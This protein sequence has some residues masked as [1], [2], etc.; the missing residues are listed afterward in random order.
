M[1]IIFESDSPIYATESELD[2]NWAKEVQASVSAVQDAISS[3]STSARGTPEV[4][5]SSLMAFKSSMKK[6]K[7]TSMMVQFA[8]T[9]SNQLSDALKMLSSLSSNFMGDVRDA[10]LHP[11]DTDMT[12]ELMNASKKISESVNGLLGVCMTGKPGELESISTLQAITST[13][14][15]LDRVNDHFARPEDYASINTQVN[16]K[17]K[18]LM[19]LGNSLSKNV[20]AKNTVEMVKKLED[21]SSNLINL[22]DDVSKLAFIVGATATKLD[23]SNYELIDRASFKI[24]VE[25]IRSLMKEIVDPRNSDSE[26]LRNLNEI[27][28]EKF[29]K[30]S[31]IVKNA[32]TNSDVPP[33]V[34]SKLYEFTKNL[35][36]TVLGLLTKLELYTEKATPNNL[37]SCEEFSKII[38]I[39]LNELQSYVNSSDLDPNKVEMNPIGLEAQKNL[40]DNVKHLLEAFYSQIDAARESITDFD[41]EDFSSALSQRTKE[42]SAAIQNFVK[43]AASNTPGQKQCQESII[44][45]N[46]LSSIIDEALIEST[47]GT[48][49]LQNAPEVSS[50]IEIINAFS[51]LIDN[52]SLCA[53]SGSYQ[54]GACVSEIPGLIEQAY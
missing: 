10:F 27:A 23:L 11:D 31:S 3:L 52:V 43:S 40:V 18:Q 47:M 16:A 44:K 46:D 7:R 28:L 42:I 37:K 24:A 6:L 20:S 12:T 22:T 51:S 5:K 14:S 45:L 38:E 39:Q 36:Q 19:L 48:M 1:T 33:H 41:N 26:I 4:M 2:T 54:L 34:Q 32:C 49:V 53:S 17:V 15:K 30:L 8:D 9:S 25:E 35:T 50:V 13:I 21:I 29:A